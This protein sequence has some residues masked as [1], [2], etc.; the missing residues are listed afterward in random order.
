MKGLR[1]ILLGLCLAVFLG[2]PYIPNTLLY[3]TV[4]SYVGVAVLLGAS[5]VA[6]RYDLLVGLAVFLAAGAL[7]LE[8]RKRL[9]VRSETAGP[10]T[11]GSP[12]AVA[13]LSVPAEPVMEDE[14]HPAFE[15]PTEEEHAFEPSQ[16][17]GFQN[18]FSPVGTSIDSK[19]PLMT[20]SSNSSQRSAEFFEK[21]G[22]SRL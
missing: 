1:V 7:F 9:V 5:L 15:K 12:A 6:V 21:Q 13:T 3:A 11:P 2:A 16:Q 17:E 10:Q 19:K 8:N 18:E 14:V 22:L 20:V 4:N